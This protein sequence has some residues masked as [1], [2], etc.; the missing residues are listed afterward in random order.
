[1][2]FQYSSEDI[3]DNGEIHSFWIPVVVVHTSDS[4][5]FIG[6]WTNAKK[7]LNHGEGPTH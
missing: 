3:E 7:C 4:K 6:N 2:W 1:M 5:D